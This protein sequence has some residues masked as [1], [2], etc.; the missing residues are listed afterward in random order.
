MRPVQILRHE[1]NDSDSA[2]NFFGTYFSTD[3][4]TK[5]AIDFY[6]YYRHKNDNQPNLDP[7]NRVDPQGTFNGPAGHYAT[8]G[9]AQRILL[10]NSTDGIMPE[11]SLTRWARFF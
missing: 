11:S 8:L 6:V 7:T 3:Y 5:Q 1:F 4:G 9:R 10:T 2:D